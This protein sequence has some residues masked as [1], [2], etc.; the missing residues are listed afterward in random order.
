MLG[1]IDALD[2]MGDDYPTPDGTAVRDYIHVCDLAEAHVQAVQY[3]EQG[4]ET[5]SMNLGVGRGYSVKEIIDAVRRATGRSVPLRQAPR[6]PGD[7]PVLVADP[8]L[9]RRVLGFEPKWTDI[10]AIIASAWR[11]AETNAGNVEAAA[12]S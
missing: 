5:I 3:L 10:E 6:R 8:A 7:P 11:W 1:Q 9:A 2:V 4:G 12:A